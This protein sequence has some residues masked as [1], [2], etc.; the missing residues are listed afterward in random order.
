[1]TAAS[2]GA[3]G[4]YSRR[5][6]SARSRASESEYAETP[7]PRCP[8]TGNQNRRKEPTKLSEGLATGVRLT[9]NVKLRAIL[10][11]GQDAADQGADEPTGLQPDATTLA[12][13]SFNVSLAGSQEE[14]HAA[15]GSIGRGASAGT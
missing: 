4:Q 3:S 6:A 12:P 7:I 8:G 14:L 5:A 13:V 1:M 11:S 2:S 9:P 10:V 15:G